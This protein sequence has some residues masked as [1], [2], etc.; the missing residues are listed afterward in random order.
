M[1]SMSRQRAT[2]PCAP[3]G[4]PDSIDA[5]LW[6]AADRSAVEEQAQRLAAVRGLSLS[7]VAVT[8]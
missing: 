8:V 7:G 6:D 1:G 5:E 3:H 2:A 4:G